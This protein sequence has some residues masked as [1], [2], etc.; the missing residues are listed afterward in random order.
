MSK[1]RSVRVPVSCDYS[2][3]DYCYSVRYCLIVMMTHNRRTYNGC[4]LPGHCRSIC[5]HPAADVRIADPPRRLVASFNLLR[6]PHA[7]T[8]G[9]A[10]QIQSP[11]TLVILL[12][13][14]GIALPPVSIIRLRLVRP[15]QQQPAHGVNETPPIRRTIYGTM[16]TTATYRVSRRKLLPTP[17][18]EEDGI[19][20]FEPRRAR[21]EVGASDKGLYERR[22][23]H[24]V[25]ADRAKSYTLRVSVPAAGLGV[26]TAPHHAA[27]RRHRRRR[28]ARRLW[29]AVQQ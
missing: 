23:D 24:P 29:S 25:R 8:G 15:T 18:P 27:R 10:R 21:T 20:F 28:V 14:A 4:Y 12:V 13:G 5:L 19:G 17:H 7:P 16:A 9:A 3:S 22:A 2:N 11:G 1:S 6:P 26:K